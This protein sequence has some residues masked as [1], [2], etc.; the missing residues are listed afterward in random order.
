[1][2][3]PQRRAV[4]VRLDMEVKEKADELAELAQVSLTALVQAAVEHMVHR[5]HEL[6]GDLPKLSGRCVFFERAA[7]IDAERRSRR[8]E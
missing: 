2:R 6:E 3:Q 4:I 7:E 5:A 1:V 8:Q